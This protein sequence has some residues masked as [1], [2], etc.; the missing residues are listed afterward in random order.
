[1]CGLPHIR[2]R[3]PH[4]FGCS[5]P[6]MCGSNSP[7]AVEEKMGLFSP[8]ATKFWGLFFC[9]FFDKFILNLFAAFLFER[10]K[11]K[12]VAFFSVRGWNKASKARKYRRKGTSMIRMV[13]YPPVLH[14]PQKK[15]HFADFL[16]KSTTGSTSTCGFFLY[17][18][19]SLCHYFSY[20]FD[21]KMHHQAMDS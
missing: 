8:Q 2:F 19:P 1:M 6:Q 21:P 4:F 14:R 10:T 12:L 3:L 15:C 17:D 16:H 20:T 11:F 18:N 13:A 5:P 9:D 7:N